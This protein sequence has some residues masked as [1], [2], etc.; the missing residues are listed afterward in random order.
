[1]R[2]VVICSSG[3]VFNRHVLPAYLAS[4]S[5]LV[6]IVAIDDKPSDTWR[7]LKHEWRRSRWHILDVVAF[8]VAYR[9]RSAARD[10]EW[11]E[12]RAASELA[13][14]EPL[15]AVPVHR[16]AD[17]NSS[18]TR[19]FLELVAPDFGVAA[20]KTLLQREIFSVPRHG[21]FVV[22]PGI[23]PEYRNAHGCFWA[24]ARRDLDRVGATLLRIDEGVDTGAIFAYYTT[25]IDERAESH[26]VI[27]LRVVY[28]NLR[29]IGD[30]L[31]RVVAGEAAPIDTTGRTSTAWGQPRLSD[32]RRWKRA[33]RSTP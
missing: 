10:A 11:I 29:Q 32:Y 5:E 16:T 24:L 13:R 15:G 4:I 21:T 19:A 2:S 26:V 22:H 20:C 25:D 14:L 30:D 27:Q 31:R 8:R 7:R 33:A 18:E 12:A 1:V 3:N 9:L 17:V 28:D 23:C 6:G